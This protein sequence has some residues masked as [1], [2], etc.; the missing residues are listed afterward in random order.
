MPFDSRWASHKQL[1][2]QAAGSV[3][4]LFMHG[5]VTCGAEKEAFQRQIGDDR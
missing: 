5:T 1:I 3:V 2:K 4:S